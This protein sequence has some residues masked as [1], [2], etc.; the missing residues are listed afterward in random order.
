MREIR[1]E[2]RP[3]VRERSSELTER[4]CGIHLPGSRQKGVR[5]KKLRACLVSGEQGIEC[6]S[7]LY[8]RTFLVETPSLVGREIDF[9]QQSGIHQSRMAGPPELQQMLK[10]DTCEI[11]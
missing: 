6:R 9:L 8:W 1:Y 4:M 11:R 3:G 10:V 5:L 2:A 7:L